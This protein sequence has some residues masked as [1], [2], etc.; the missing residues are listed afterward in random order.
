M[1]FYKGYLIPASGN[2]NNN[3]SIERMHRENEHLR[4]KVRKLEKTVKRLE[5]SQRK[6]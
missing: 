5:K 4:Y 2:I 3:D 6:N 1:E